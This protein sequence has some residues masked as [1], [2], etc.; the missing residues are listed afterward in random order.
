MT[1]MVP[2]HRPSCDHL[3]AA[4]SDMV[5]VN[6]NHEVAQDEGLLSPS[7]L[8]DRAWTYPGRQDLPLLLFCPM[9]RHRLFLL[10]FVQVRSEASSTLGFWRGAQLTGVETVV[11]GT[12]ALLVRVLITT[13]PAIAI[14]Q[15]Q[16]QGRIV[17]GG[18]PN[19][20]TFIMML[21]WALWGMT[22]TPRNP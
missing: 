4:Q 3:A 18:H 11:K 6:L 7:P 5:A 10:C 12:E 20:I 17:R 16:L 22:S 14:L 21:G 13:I 15:M 1:T 2:H 9:H 8:L 19:I